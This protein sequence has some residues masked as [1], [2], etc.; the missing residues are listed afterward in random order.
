MDVAR[1]RSLAVSQAALCTRHPTKSVAEVAGVQQCAT[2][3]GPDGKERAGRAVI[4]AVTVSFCC[5]HTAQLSAD[6]M[7]R[8]FRAV[9]DI[10]L[11]RQH[12]LIVDEVFLVLIKQLL[13]L[14]PPG[15]GCSHG[16]SV[17]LAPV[18]CKAECLVLLS[19][20]MADSPNRPSRL[21]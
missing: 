11:L 9:N 10:W 13:Q 5:L 19:P 1:T 17:L 12:S 18:T 2:N 4:G 20:S 14:I 3:M 15:S 21:T 6:L 8:R 7:G 16:R